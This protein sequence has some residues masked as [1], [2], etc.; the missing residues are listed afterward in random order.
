[1]TFPNIYLFKIMIIKTIIHV[2]GGKLPLPHGHNL[3]HFLTTIMTVVIPALV[4]PG[5]TSA[6]CWVLTSQAVVSNPSR[7]QYFPSEG[8]RGL[9][10]R[11]VAF[12]TLRGVKNVSSDF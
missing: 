9:E 6:Y 11:C 3:N 12:P 5:A 2:H 10:R 1:M 4:W 7:P 8:F